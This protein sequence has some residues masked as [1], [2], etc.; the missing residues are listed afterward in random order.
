MAQVADTGKIGIL[1]A[2]DE[3]KR[4]LERVLV[5]SRVP[6]FRENGIATYFTRRAEV[7][8]LVGGTGRE[9]AAV[10]TRR[11]LDAGVNVLI[12]AGFAA[13]LDPCA[14][15]GDVL[16]GNNVLLCGSDVD[17]VACSA[18]IRAL[19]PPSRAFGFPIRVCNVATGDSIAFSPKQK[20]EIFDATGAAVYDMESYAAAQICSERGVPFAA[21]R[22][23]SD[24]AAQRVP[25][26]VEE[27]SQAGNG[28]LRAALVASTPSA[29]LSLWKLRRQAHVAAEHLADVLGTMLIRIP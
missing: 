11:L 23:V 25:E 21:I 19:L 10:G 12:C 6:G 26:V 9:R 4:G 29:W 28:V 2:L 16:V 1:F 17:P 15:V 3:E 7:V 24:T 22:G 5:E 20:G 13:A 27:L 8:M 18:S 14:G